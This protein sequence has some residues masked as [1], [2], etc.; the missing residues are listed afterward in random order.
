MKKIILKK[1]ESF[2]R[3][4][5][6]LSGEEMRVECLEAS[7][8]YHTFDELYDHRIELFIALCK[9]VRLWNESDPK[10][11]WRSRSHHAGGEP[12]YDGWFVMGIEK[13]HG[14]Q[15]SYH[16]PLSRWDETDFAETLDNAPEWDGHTPQDVINRLKKL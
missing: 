10:E 2:H 1:V 16:L 11:V 14:S 5:D 12:M 4:L 6:P 3:I 9:Q 13:K 7:D 15:I 8:G